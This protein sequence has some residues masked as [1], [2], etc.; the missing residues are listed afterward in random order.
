MN[1]AYEKKAEREKM[2]QAVV[3]RCEVPIMARVR[4]ITLASCVLVLHDKFGFGKKR[5]E[6]FVGEVADTFDSLNEGYINFEDI[7]ATIYDELGI[8]F[9]EAEKYLLEKHKKFSE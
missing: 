6:K 5:L 1:R 7:K 4:C 9:D 8:D 2:I 3:K